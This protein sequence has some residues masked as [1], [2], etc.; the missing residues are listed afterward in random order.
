M[1]Q[2]KSQPDKDPKTRLE[3]YLS[4]YKKPSKEDLENLPAAIDFVLK[5]IAERDME[6]RIEIERRDYFLHSFIGKA[7]QRLGLTESDAI[8]IKNECDKDLAANWKKINEAANQWVEE[9]LMEEQFRDQFGK[10]LPK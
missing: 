8:E 10:D 4:L 9:R 3:S 2:D 7:L 5:F 6:Y 1:S